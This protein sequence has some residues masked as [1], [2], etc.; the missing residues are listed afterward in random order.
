MFNFEKLFIDYRVPYSTRV[1]KGWVNSNCIYCDTKEDSFNL[2]FNPE[3][4]CN[5]WKC[6]SHN[7]NKTL[8]LILHISENQIKDILDDYKGNYKQVSQSIKKYTHKVLSLPTDTFTISEENYLKSRNFDV[9]YLHRKY[10]LV[11]GGVVGRYKFRIIIPIYYKNRLVSFISRSILRGSELKEYGI[12]RYLN[13][14]NEESLMNVKDIFYNL[15]NCNL[16]TVILT[17]GCFDVMRLG[18][19]DSNSDNVI[20]SLGTTI[21]QAQI[22]LLSERFKKVYI[23]FDNEKEAQDKARKYAMQIS[24]FGIGVEV[25]DAYSDYN[26][27]DGAELNQKQVNEIRAELFH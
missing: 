25:V 2:G 14:S 11:G 20:C 22:R 17:E 5:C 9:D 4:Y 10:K 7:L 26:V 24:A 6:G 1:N 19:I 16:D 18:D 8:S 21:T 12:P 13:L 3:G 27:N 23:M 15:D